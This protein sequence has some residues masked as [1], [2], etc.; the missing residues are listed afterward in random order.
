MP[1]LMLR[2]L[3]PLAI[4]STVATAQAPD[5]NVE[6]RAAA[7]A[8]LAA[9]QGSDGAT[10]ER[11]LAPEFLFVR[12]SGRVGGRRDFIDG[13]TAPGVKLEPIVVT[14]RLFQRVSADVVVIGGEAQ[15]RGTQNGRALA[16]HYRFADTFVRRDGRWLVIFSQITPLPLP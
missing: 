13:F 3:V 14:D 4:M 2:A 5:N 15:L 11:T 8:F 1:R 10:L 12:S 16:Q 7:D 9:Q 6:A